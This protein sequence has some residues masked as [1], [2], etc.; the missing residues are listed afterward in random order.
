MQLVLKPCGKCGL[1]IAW[2]DD[3]N[4]QPCCLPS[5]R[6]NFSS[7]PKWEDRLRRALAT[8]S[9]V[10]QWLGKHD[11]HVEAVKLGQAMRDVR[12]VLVGLEGGQDDGEATP[13]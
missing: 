11:G 1:E 3:S 13:T 4:E 9:A 10:N 6:A 8:M 7:H 12:W 2:P 5:C